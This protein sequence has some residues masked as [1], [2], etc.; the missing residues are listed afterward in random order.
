MKKI[1]IPATSRKTC[2]CEKFLRKTQEKKK[3]S[4]FLSGTVFC[5]KKINSCEQDYAT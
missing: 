5:V 4:G 2:S 1:G 3:S